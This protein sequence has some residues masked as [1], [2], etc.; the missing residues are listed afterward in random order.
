MSTNAPGA[1]LQRKW[2]P[3]LP[4]LTFVS[5]RLRKVGKLETVALGA[6]VA[7]T[8]LLVLVPLLVPYGSTDHVGQSLTGPTSRHWMG[9]DEQGRDVLSRVLLGMRTSWF[10]A[11]EV[12]ASGVLIGGSI[13]LV[14][15]MTGGWVDNLLMR[16][17]DVFLALPGPLL[18]LAVVSA[19]GPSL[20]HTLVAVAIVWWPFYARIV[21]GEVR[22]IASRSHVEAARMGGAGRLRVAFHHVV[23]GTFGA[24]LVTASLDIGALLLTLAGLS[25]LGLGSPAPA[26]ELGAM[27]SRGLSYLFDSWWV[28]VFP[29]LGVFVLAFIGNVAG[30]GI[31][32][33]VEA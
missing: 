18:V 2:V 25:F 17:T 20:T 14:A 13:G 24:V 30:D 21:R 12:I 27:T 7:V 3:T 9:I 26:P 19:L 10:A 5:D 15:G 4:R 33:V 28:P 11:F 22:S 31:R 6:F 29:A 32:D 1:P 23:P 16:I 8:L